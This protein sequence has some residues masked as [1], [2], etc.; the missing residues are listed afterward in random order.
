MELKEYARTD[1]YFLSKVVI[2][3]ENWIYVNDPELKHQSSQWNC[4]S[5]L[6][7]EEMAASESQHDVNADLLFRQ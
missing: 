2:G 7:A 6:S 3:D 1:P 5:S 4:P